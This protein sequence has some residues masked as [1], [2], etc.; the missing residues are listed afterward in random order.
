M[1]G[2]GQYFEIL[3]L[4]KFHLSYKNDCYFTNT[5]RKKKRENIFLKEEIIIF[6]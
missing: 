6:C 5:K 2:V 3:L 4:A 1:K